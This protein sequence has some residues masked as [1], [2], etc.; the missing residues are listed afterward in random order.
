MQNYLSLTEK[1]RKTHEQMN[2]FAIGLI[3]SKK[4]IE[5]F[6]PQLEN[7]RQMADRDIRNYKAACDRLY[8]RLIEILDDFHLQKPKEENPNTK[9]E[10]FIKAR[11]EDTLRRENVISFK[12]EP[13]E[14][15]D[16]EKHEVVS[17]IID[18]EKLEGTIV[19]IQKPG[20]IQDQKILRRAEIVI[21]YREEK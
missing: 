20:Y 9:F 4:D 19:K 10:E 12:V 2:L 17:R 3:K 7:Y 11:L 1:L 21:T 8:I 6:I 13:G 14:L 5:D 18:N 16:P 15:F